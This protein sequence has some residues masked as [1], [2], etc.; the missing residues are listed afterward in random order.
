MKE[1]DTKGSR[2]PGRV[3][4]EEGQGKDWELKW[5][6]SEPNDKLAPE[7]CVLFKDNYFYDSDCT[8]NFF[9]KKSQAK[10]KIIFFLP[11]SNY[12]I[13]KITRK[14]GSE[15]DSFARIIVLVIAQNTLKEI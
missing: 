12:K 8:E 10:V 13:T 2:E 4:V 14:E 6:G 11:F 3:V 7:E 9:E 5:E 1:Y 15:S